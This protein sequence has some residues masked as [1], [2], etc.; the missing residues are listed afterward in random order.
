MSVLIKI[1]ANR[2]GSRGA[3]QTEVYRGDQGDDGSELKETSGDHEE[4]QRHSRR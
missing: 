2:F 4:H 3:G 1:D